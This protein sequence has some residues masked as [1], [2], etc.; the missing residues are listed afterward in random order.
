MGPFREFLR[1]N[2]WSNQRRREGEK[3]FFCHNLIIV[4]RFFQAIDVPVLVVCPCWR[5]A[6][7]LA[8]QIIE[9]Q[10]IHH[11]LLGEERTRLALD[12]ANTASPSLH[13]IQTT[14]PEARLSDQTVLRTPTTWILSVQNV[15][16]TWLGSRRGNCTEVSTTSKCHIERIYLQLS[17]PN[18]VRKHKATHHSQVF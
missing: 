4:R 11:R 14:K 15:L 1:E 16:K 13:V 17:I 2:G 12:A 7:S 18:T 5:G 9:Q 8:S 10:N 3:F 6:T